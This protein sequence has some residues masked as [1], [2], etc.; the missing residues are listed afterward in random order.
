MAYFLKKLLD[1]EIFTSMV[2]WATNFFFEICKTLSPPP[3]LHTYCTL[4]RCK[5]HMKTPEAC[6]SN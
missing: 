2:S 5:I 6:N 4:P 1:H 3:I